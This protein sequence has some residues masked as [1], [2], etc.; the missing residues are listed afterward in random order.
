MGNGQW[1]M[2]IFVSQDKLHLH[3]SV[4]PRGLWS[5]VRCLSWPFQLNPK[6]IQLMAIL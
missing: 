5:G 4:F 1:A 2:I 6:I 3:L